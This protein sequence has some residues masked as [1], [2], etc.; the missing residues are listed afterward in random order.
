MLD[1]GNLSMNPPHLILCSHNLNLLPTN[2]DHINCRII[3]GHQGVL[4][5]GPHLFY[6][7]KIWNKRMALDHSCCAQ[8]L[9]ICLCTAALPLYL[10]FIFAP[11]RTACVSPG[12]E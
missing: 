2:T 10:I 1:A 12:P 3:T 7:A 8:K 9:H 5:H 11:P 4:A 6:W